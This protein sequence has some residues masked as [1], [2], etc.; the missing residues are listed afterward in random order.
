[1]FCCLSFTDLCFDDVLVVEVEAWQL[2]E[3]R[4]DLGYFGRSMMVF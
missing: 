4:R 1:M 3:V 2:A